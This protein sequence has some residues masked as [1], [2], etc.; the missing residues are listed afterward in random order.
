[1]KARTALFL[2][3]VVGGAAFGRDLTFF[4]WSDTHFGAYDYA[5]TT[6]LEVIRQMNGLPGTRY[7]AEIFEDAKVGRPAFLLHLGDIT[8][9]GL[10]GEWDDPNLADQRSYMRTLRYLTV[11]DKIYEVAGNHDSRQHTNI[12]GQI[13]R[14][15]DNTYYAFEMEGVHFVVLDLYTHLNGGT[16]SLDDEQLDWLRAYLDRIDDTTPVIIAMHAPP[17]HR[18][19]ADGLSRQADDTLEHL[20]HIV[21]DKNVLAFFHGHIH[22]V[23]AGRWFEFDTV[24]PAGFAYMRRGCPQGDPVFGVVRITDDRMTVCGWDWERRCFMEKPVLDKFFRSAGGEGERASTSA[25]AVKP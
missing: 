23:F 24:A 14:R 16:P 7:P 17:P 2:V 10:A 19:P 21:A 22:R 20:W 11:T 1:M 6:R 25:E 9:H 3:L 15:Q 18:T 13:A 8:E 12:R 4:V 5:D